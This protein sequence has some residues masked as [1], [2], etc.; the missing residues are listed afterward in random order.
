MTRSASIIARAE[1]VTI[2]DRR[3]ERLAPPAVFASAKGAWCADLEGNE[4]ID[5][6]ASSG[7]VLLGHGD[8]G[9]AEA[10]VE[11]ARAG[12]V[13]LAD[14]VTVPLV[15][16]AERLVARYPAAQ[17]VAF[18]KTGSEATTAAVRLA[19]TAT[20]R[21]WILSAGY[22]GWHDW[23]L[24]IRGY[25]AN[26]DHSVIHFG[27]HVE[28]LESLLD[29]LS[30]RVA[31]V[32]V[33]P[34]PAWVSMEA[35]AVMGDACRR[36]SVPFILDE[37]MTGLRF[38]PSGVNGSGVAA[39]VIVLA[40]GLANGHAIAAVAGRDDLVGAYHAAG[41]GGTYN[42]EVVPLVAARAVLDATESGAVHR[43]ASEAG[44]AIRDGV[45]AALTR[46]GIPVWVGGP[47]LMFDVVLPTA[48]CADVF[49]TA[50]FEGGVHMDRTG[51]QFVTGAHAGRE[52]DAVI[53][54]AEKAAGVVAARLG[55]LPAVDDRRL[56]DFAWDAFGGVMV[57]RPEWR[58]DVE[59]VL[60]A[61]SGAGR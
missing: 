55:E 33:S 25:H 44:T 12:A 50:M 54:A 51:T 3:P 22:H 49:F 2:R 52:V 19:R 58:S 40:K 46:A 27:Y 45:A 16:V 42:R 60:D 59:R 36:H 17:R 41:L 53:A 38:G 5:L 9:V 26:V 10:V 13:G 23:Q 21:R 37:V 35:L 18:F 30:G 15:E 4:Y 61:V 20:G 47:P 57:A 7:A 1:A 29:G 31:G 56:R 32:I 43:R 11:A 24:G 28:A 6:T 48:A 34:E 39:D 8:A 14:A